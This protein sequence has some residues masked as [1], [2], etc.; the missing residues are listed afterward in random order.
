M[1]KLLQISLLILVY[2]K[3]LSH[4]FFYLFSS[5]KSASE[6]VYPMLFMLAYLFSFSS[7]SSIC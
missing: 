6:H 4:F 5:P 3:A 1:R 2:G 7:S